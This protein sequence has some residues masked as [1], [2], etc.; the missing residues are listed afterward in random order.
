MPALDR[1]RK[2]YE[3]NRNYPEYF[4]AYGER[5]PKISPLQIGFRLLRPGGEQS[6][7]IG[8]INVVIS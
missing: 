5:L 8:T 6:R 4:I 1:A 3:R 7:Q 2:G